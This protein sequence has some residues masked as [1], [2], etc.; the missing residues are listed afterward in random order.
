MKVTRI[1]EDPR[2]TRPFDEAQW[3]AIEKLGRRVDR[4][5]ADGDVRLTMGGEP[6]FVSVDDMDGAEWNYAA[7]LA[8]Q[9]RARRGPPAPPAQAL[10]AGRDAALR[11]GQVVSRGAAAALGALVL[12]AP[13]R[14]P[15]LERGAGASGPARGGAR[16]ARGREALRR[17]ARAG[18]RPRR[19]ARPARLRGPLADHSRR[20]EPAG[21]PR[22]ARAGPRGWRGAREARRAA[23]RQRRGRGGLRASA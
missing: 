8:A 11:P 20:D 1:H 15:A 7:L 5:L 10:R 17:R 23:R 9:A 6:T 13:R 14:R 21:E 16:V 3:A 4:E 18:A 12:L 2:V 22:S 19:R